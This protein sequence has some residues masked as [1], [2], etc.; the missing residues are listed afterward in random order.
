L[1]AVLREESWEEEEEELESDSFSFPLDWERV[2]LLEEDMVR[3][4]NVS[5]TEGWK[6]GVRE[7]R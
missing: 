5:G 2:I 7:R 3:F 6:G 1:S 4:G